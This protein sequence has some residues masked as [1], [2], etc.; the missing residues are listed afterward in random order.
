MHISSQTV[1]GVHSMSGRGCCWPIRDSL[2]DWRVKLRKKEREQEEEEEE[3][4]V[5]AMMMMAVAVAGGLKTEA[6]GER[7][8]QESG[9]TFTLK[10]LET[11]GFN[12]ISSISV[13]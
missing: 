11:T 2:S 13:W 4:E 1:F 12:K 6:R 8:E 5:L 10:P 9:R 7:E 3:G